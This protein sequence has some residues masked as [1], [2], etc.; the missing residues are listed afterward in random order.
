[1]AIEFGRRI[2][3]VSGRVLFLLGF[4]A[5]AAV[6]ATVTVPA[7][8]DL[9]AA[10]DGAQPGDVILLA[11]GATY[12]GHFRLPVKEGSAYITVRTA[13]ADGALPAAE[14]RVGPQHASALAKLASPDLSAPTLTTAA[15][16]HHWRIE[17]VE[18]VGNGGADMITLGAGGSQT[19]MTQMPHDLV[20]DRVYIHGDPVLGQKRGIALNSGSTHIR[21]SYI[22]D[23]KAVGVDSQAICGWNGAGPFVIENNYLEA[24]GENVMFGGADPSIWSLVP[25]DITVRR[26]VLSKPVAW[27]SERWSIKNAFELKNARRVLVEGNVIE[28]VWQAAQTGIAFLI[29]PRNQGGTAPWSV[30]EDVTVQYNVIRHAG[31]VF[32]ISGFDDERPSDQTR[33]IRIANNLAYDIDSA[34]WGGSARFVQIGNQPADVAIEKNTVV[35]SGNVISAYGKPITGFVFR[36]NLVRHNTYGVIGDNYAVGNATLQAYFPGATFD[37]NVLAGGNAGAYPAGNYFPSLQ[38]FE[39]GFTS[40]VRENFALGAGSSFR[41]AASDGG[42]IGADIDRVSTM[43]TATGATPS[44]AAIVRYAVPRTVPVSSR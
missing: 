22:A 10:L 16:A 43:T 5:S 24:A 3:C 8:G 12:I 29:T 6:A 11:S 27:R 33:R 26:N 34:G 44:A 40:M 17:L 1:V 14:T 7:G 13:A 41:T 19:E 25:S 38:E 42:P 21:N 2:A 9:Q 36:D 20:F 23:I 39:A 32:N 30:V 15:G 31:G 28:N 4:S 18:F 37:R 35:Q